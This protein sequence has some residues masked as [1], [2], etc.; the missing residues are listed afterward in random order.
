M[1]AMRMVMKQ[2]AVAA[3]FSLLV[4][5]ALAQT[6]QPRTAGDDWPMFSH[7]FGGTRF[8]PLTDINIG[9]VSGL[10]QVPAMNQ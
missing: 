10:T 3:A 7:D 5:G 6:G 2:F 9:N 4:A 8:S 1:T